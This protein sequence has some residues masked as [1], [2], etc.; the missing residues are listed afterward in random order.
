MQLQTKT[1]LAR[2]VLTAFVKTTTSKDRIDMNALEVSNLTKRFGTFV[3][4]D[5]ISFTIP[6]GVIFGLIGR[7][8]AGKT[9]TIRM[10]MNI[11]EADSGSI[12]FRGNSVGQAFRDRV[13]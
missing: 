2:P 11:Y 6:E 12:L 7:N 5:N 13:G 3:A 9:T 1:G 8:G 10:L 4:V